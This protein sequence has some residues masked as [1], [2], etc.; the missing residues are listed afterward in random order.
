MSSGED[1]EL[2][3]DDDINEGLDG[4][5]VLFDNVV[6]L[7]GFWLACPTTSNDFIRELGIDGITYTHARTHTHTHA[8]MHAR[9]PH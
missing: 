3:D 5:E 7:V 2:S 1:G 6:G 8:L 9:T 4:D